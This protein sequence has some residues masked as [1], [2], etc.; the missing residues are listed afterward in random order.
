MDAVAV[1]ALALRLRL[2]GPGRERDDH[3]AVADR[4]PGFFVN[5]PV[6]LIVDGVADE[7][8]FRSFGPPRA[9][10]PFGCLLGCVEAEF[11]VVVVPRR[12]LAALRE[13]VDLVQVADAPPTALAPLVGDGDQAVNVETMTESEQS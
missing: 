5:R 6:R 12:L 8:A 10:R 4:L 2:V 11:T 3:R 13:F 9:G 7:Q 1:A